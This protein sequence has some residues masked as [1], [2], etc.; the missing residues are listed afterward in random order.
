MFGRI[1]FSQFYKVTHVTARFLGLK[2]LFVDGI[3]SFRTSNVPFLS[4]EL[5]QYIYLFKGLPYLIL[6]LLIS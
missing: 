1:F 5:S 3:P 6:G 4:P 2:K